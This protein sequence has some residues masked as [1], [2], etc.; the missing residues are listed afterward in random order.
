MVGH[1]Y[2][3][4]YYEGSDIMADVNVRILSAD[5]ANSLG[6]AKISEFN[7]IDTVDD[8]DYLLVSGHRSGE[9]SEITRKITIARIARYFSEE[10]DVRNKWFIPVVRDDVIHWELHWI[11]EVGNHENDM[12][13]PYPIRPIYI[14]DL[15]GDATDQKSGLLNPTYKQRLDTLVPASTSSDGLMSKEDK[16]KLDGIEANANNYVLPTATTDVLGGVK[17]DNRTIVMNANGVIR[18]NAG[19]PD[20]R[21]C[22]LP[23]TDWDPIT[24]TL[25]LD[26]S[27][28]VNMRNI[29]DVDPA[30]VDLW[31]NNKIYAI[32]ETSEG[33]TF[34]CDQIPTN[35]IVI[36]IVS[37]MVNVIESE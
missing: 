20:S 29:I 16:G 5:D 24:L 37:T 3:L 32:S 36:F 35:D 8:A 4:L 1:C 14:T 31:V 28:N 26:I 15:I 18:S 27:I 11:D 7:E 34:R 22:V 33:I 2:K 12:A 21:R 23:Y 9:E 17:I 10:T 19:V 6:F 25:H 30:S 13:A